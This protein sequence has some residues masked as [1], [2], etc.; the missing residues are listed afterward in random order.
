MGLSILVQRTVTCL[1][2]FA[3]DA[4]HLPRPLAP[5]TARIGGAKKMLRAYPPDRKEE[6]VVSQIAAP[7]EC[8]W[9]A[10]LFAS[11]LQDL[12]LKCHRRLQRLRKTRWMS[13][14]ESNNTNLT[15]R[16][17]YTWHEKN[18]S[19]SS[20]SGKPRTFQTTQRRL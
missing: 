16:S 10:Q 5:W 1:F 8:L 17:S 13:T 18:L 9:S 6:A 4:S 12:C 2:V 7:A 3:Y 11:H 20:A 14:K 19:V 15:P